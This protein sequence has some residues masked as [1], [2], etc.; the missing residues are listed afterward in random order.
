MGDNFEHIETI[1]QILPQVYLKQVKFQ[2]RF[3]TVS[4]N[5]MYMYM[6]VIQRM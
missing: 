3:Y 4:Q 6:Y 2:H 1:G 5:Y